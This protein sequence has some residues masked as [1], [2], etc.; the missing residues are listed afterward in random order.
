MSK[1]ANRTPLVFFFVFIIPPLPSPPTNSGGNFILCCKIFNVVV[2]FTRRPRI[3]SFNRIRRGKDSYTRLL[4]FLLDLHLHQLTE[5]WLVVAYVI[6]S[7]L[8]F[9]EIWHVDKNAHNNGFCSCTWVFHYKI[10][11][12]CRY[13][14][15]PISLHHLRL[16]CAELCMSYNLS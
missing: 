8:D 11:R 14:V 3:P 12:Q 13:G 15:E 16:F 2:E 10:A 1:P 4:F 7:E 6:L 5:S 9:P